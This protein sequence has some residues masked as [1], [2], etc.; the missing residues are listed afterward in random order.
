M[1]NTI[2]ESWK[3]SDEMQNLFLFFQRSEEA[4]SVNA[5]DSYRLPVCNAIVLQNEIRRIY[6]F[7]YKNNQIDKYYSKY[8]SCIID[9]LIDSIKKDNVLKKHLGFRK[10]RILA[11]LK[12]AKSNHE[13]LIRWLNVLAHLC[14]LENH[15]ADCKAELIRTI[16]EDCD[17]KDLLWCIDN[18]YIDLH[19]K[20][21]SIEYLYQSI[22]R[23]FDSRER[24]ID[25][26]DRINTFLSQFTLEDNEYQFYMVVDTF[27]FDAIQ[28]IDNTWSK[29]IELRV[30]EEQEIKMQ[31]HAGQSAKKLVEKYNELKKR[32][33]ESVK[34]VSCKCEAVDPYS[35]FE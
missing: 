4:L 3:Y 2:P 9:E 15:L 33:E 29:S 21:Y 6:L 26:I 12:S 28:R 34:I 20:G 11:G 32:G 13:E 19:A 35:A 17:Q 1:I 8:I 16:K 24:T 23:F 31:K 10:E 27:K 30:V 22:I 18:F 25:T 7:L 5:I 14:S